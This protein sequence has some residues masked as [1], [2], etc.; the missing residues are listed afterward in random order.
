MTETVSPPVSANG[1]GSALRSRPGVP[2]PTRQRRPA[3]IALLVLLVVGL[4]A[5]GAYWYSKAGAK[6]PVVV[7]TQ[8]VPAGHVITRSDLSTVDVA[9]SVAAIDGR[10]LEDLVGRTATVDLLPGTLLQ[11]SMETTAAALPPGLVRVGV[12][13]KPGQLPAEGVSPGGKVAVLQVPAKDTVSAAAGASSAGSSATVL[14]PAAT[15]FGAA[16][17]P[18]QPGGTVVTL[19]VPQ[20]AMTAVAAASSQGL[21]ALIGVSP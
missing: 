10:Y 13:V 9:G 12:A 14:T 21:V 6:S 18:S 20:S 15:V 16:A 4:A 5:T 19:L 3:Y 7:V 1:R 8:R 11:Q 2:V 17:D